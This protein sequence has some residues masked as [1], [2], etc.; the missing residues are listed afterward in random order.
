MIGAQA[1]IVGILAGI[2]VPQFGVFTG[3]YLF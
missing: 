1:R 2:P 3:W